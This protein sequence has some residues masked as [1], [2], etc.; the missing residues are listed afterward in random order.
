MKAHFVY[1]NPKV[2]SD[3]GKA[4]LMKGPLVYCLEETDNG[5]NLAKDEQA[6]DK[7]AELTESFPI[8]ALEDFATETRKMAF[9][10][11]IRDITLE[12]YETVI[13]KP[14]SQNKKI[15]EDLYKTNA[16]RPSIGFGK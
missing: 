5:Q 14:E 11:G 8:R 7:I 12:D 9:V 16:T 15:K 3:T 13:A 2:R 1:A 10:K 6:L 4:A